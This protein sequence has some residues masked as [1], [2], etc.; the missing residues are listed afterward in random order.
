[1]S[2]T[3]AAFLNTAMSI[4]TQEASAQEGYDYAKTSLSEEKKMEHQQILDTAAQAVPFGVA[5]A[6]RGVHGLWETKNRIYAFK[7]K[8]APMVEEFKAKAATAYENI[9]KEGGE[10]VDFAG[11]LKS[12]GTKIGKQ[13]LELAAPEILK[14]TGIDIKAAATAAKGEGGIAAGLKNLG[15]QGIDVA[16]GK[17][18]GTAEESLARV[19]S[20]VNVAAQKVQTAAEMTAAKF[21]PR[22]IMEQKAAAEA[23][24][25][26][27][28]IEM[29]PMTGG[30][31]PPPN[32]PV[33]LPPSLEALRTVH[34]EEV[35]APVAA[36]SAVAKNPAASADLRAEAQTHLDLLAEHSKAIAKVQQEHEVPKA[37]LEDKFNAAETARVQAAAK[38]EELSRGTK[39]AAVEGGNRMVGAGRSGRVL[40]GQAKPAIAQNPELTAART[41]LATQTAK[42]AELQTAGRELKTSFGQ[43]ITAVREATAAKLSSLKA[44]AGAKITETIGET[45][46]AALSTGAKVAGGVLGV[47]MDA[48]AI[49]GAE[50]GAKE[51]VTGQARGAQEQFGDTASVYMGGRATA[52]VGQKVGGFVASKIAPKAGTAA[53]EKVAETAGI[54]AGTAAGK[55]AAST[56][57][58]EVSEDIAKQTAKMAAEKV[59]EKIGTTLAVEGAEIGAAAAGSSVIPVVGEA[60][61]IGLGLYTAIDALVNIFKKTPSA[62]PPPP[63]P[64]QA[65]AVLH[66]QG[67]Y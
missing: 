22:A 54:K 26:K 15:D 8:Y 49:Y 42:V 62:P 19:K 13:A 60:V 29:Q 6:V 32:A 11:L 52:A 24:G 58:T 10:A 25:G 41:E 43:K 66:Q 28:E 21:T 37:A 39:F 64:Q 56:A 23:R 59:G 38:V 51:L 44:A 47:G 48:A 65:V 17:L 36:I 20:G 45:A 9:G 2:N 1:M 53:G 63:P 34:G 46:S 55:E 14:R 50:Q 57:G 40:P 35:V 67:V 31:R 61:D 27:V 16:K 5:E 18:I 12:A 30:V 7:E 4:D 33:E 3:I